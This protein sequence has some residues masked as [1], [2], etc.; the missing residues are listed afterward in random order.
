MEIIT[1]HTAQNID[2]EYEIGG[3]GERIMAYLLDILIF[4]ALGIIGIILSLNIS[5]GMFEEI[6]FIILGVII[7]F[8]DLFCEAF[9][10]GQS[11]GK[12]IMKIKVI[13]LDGNRAR[14]SQYL[15]RWL[16]RM[17]DFSLTS[18]LAGII[19]IILT[20]KSQR[21][22]D[23][24]AGTVVIRT[25]PRTKMEDIVFANAEDTY[26]PIFTEASLLTDNDIGLIHE[27]INNYL[28][29]GNNTIV[30]TMADRIRK[31]LAISLPPGMNS[32]EF[33]Q[34]IIKDYSHITTQNEI[35]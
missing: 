3:A 27:V 2:I 14:F 31:H 20:E 8:Y 11:V 7:L 32:M 10:N 22:G 12:L 18:Y 15:L 29:T 13:S 1:V 25:I 33:L 34:T 28:R 4:T 5:P 16:F 23:I 24:V 21:V 35:G 19:S 9:F 6:Y 17:I 30:Y 26:Q